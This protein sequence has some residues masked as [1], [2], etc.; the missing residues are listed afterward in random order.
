MKNTVRV[1]FIINSKNG[2][3]FDTVEAVST[4]SAQQIVEARYPGMRVS[5]KNITRL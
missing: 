5:I 1:E 4:T 2:M 3:L